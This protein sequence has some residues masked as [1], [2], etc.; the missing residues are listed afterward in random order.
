MKENQQTPLRERGVGTVKLHQGCEGSPFAEE[1]WNPS[2][3]KRQ[4]GGGRQRTMEGSAALSL[5]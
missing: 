3:Y 2:K 5:A 4:Y 1:D